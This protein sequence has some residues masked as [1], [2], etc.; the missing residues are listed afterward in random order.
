[1]EGGVRPVPGGSCQAMFH[2]V[3]MNVVA[4]G[5]KVLFVADGVFPEPPLPHGTFV[6]P[7]SRFRRFWQAEPCL[8]PLGE[9]AL[10][11]APPGRIIGIPFGKLPDAMHV[12]RQ[13]HPSA[14]RERVGGFGYRRSLPLRPPVICRG[15]GSAGAD[16]L[17][18]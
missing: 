1:M 16:R 5:S 11:E 14:N 15:T 4:M 8:G 2:G 10:D 9:P 18:P 12:V 6:V 17:Q 7:G 13:Q 3:V